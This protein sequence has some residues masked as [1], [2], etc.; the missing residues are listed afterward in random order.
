M[1][2]VREDI[3]TDKSY[4]HVD[5]TR[6]K[7]LKKQ[8]FI[9]F[10]I[11][12]VC[13][14]CSSMPATVFGQAVTIEMPDTVLA[15]AVRDA[16]GFGTTDPITDVAMLDLTRL[17]ATSSGPADDKI[18]DL[19]GLEHAANL[20]W[21]ELANNTISNVGPLAKLTNLTRL[22]LSSNNLIL[23]TSP[24][25][26]PLPIPDY[27]G[28]QIK[29]YPP[30]DVNTNGSV[31][32]E[33]VER[34]MDALRG[35]AVVPENRPMD[36][37]GSGYVDH[38]DL[39]LVIENALGLM[40]VDVPD[41]HLAAV[42]RSTLELPPDFPIIATL[43]RRLT[44]LVAPG[45]A[46]TDLTG[47]ETATNLTGLDLSDNLIK[48]NLVPLASLGNLD[49]LW[50][51]N[52]AIDDVSPLFNLRNLKRLDLGGNTISNISIL[53]R[54][55]SLTHLHLWKNAI[56]DIRVLSR[57]TNLQ[58]LNL[59][60]NTI[61]DIS[62]LS[63]LTTLKRLDLY[64]NTISDIR[65]LSGLTDLTW[66]SL[67]DNSVEDVSPLLSLPN[68]RSLFLED[69]PILDTS[70][71]YPK[72]PLDVDIEIS[73][74]PP[75]DVNEDGSVD[76]T[77]TAL[78][79][80]ALG[81]SGNSIADPRTD[82][83]GDGTVN[84]ADV[85]LVNDNWRTF[86]M[87]DANLTAAVRTVLG[88]RPTET[89]I[90]QLTKLVA[91]DSLISDLTGLEYATNLA[92]LELRD[93]S[94]RD[95]R[96]LAGLTNLR[97][98][99]FGDNS[100]GDI[101][102]VAGLT[103]LRSL[104]MGGNTFSDIRPIAGLTNLERLGV[105]SL[106]IRDINFLTRL[107]KL[108]H[109]GIGGNAIS[110]IRPLARLRNLTE[111]GL[112][113]N[114][115]TD[116]SP[117]RTL[118]NL[119]ELELNS[120]Q[121]TDVSPL[122]DLTA[123]KKLLLA[124]NPVLTQN[125]GSLV[126]LLTL[127][128]LGTEK[129]D[130]DFEF[131][132][133]V[134][135][136]DTNLAAAVREAL[137]LAE[138]SPIV[139]SQ[140]Q[141]L[142]SLIAL[143][144]GIIDL[145][146]LEGATGL[147]G[148]SLD[149]NSIRDISFLASLTDLLELALK[150][151]LIDDISSLQD[152]TNL[153]ELKL[154]NNRITDVSP[155]SGLTNLRELELQNNQITDVL[156]LSGLRNLRELKLQNN[157][158]MDVSPLSGLTNLKT[159][160][161]TGNTGITNVEV[162]FRLQLGGTQIKGVTV[163]NFVVFP[164]ANLETAVRTALSL[165]PNQPILLS[166]LAALTT[167]DA[168][169]STIA[170]LSGLE[171]ATAL[172]S[173]D[174][175][176]N[177]IT[178]VS[179]L[180]AATALTSLDLRDNQITDVS[181]L[182]GLTNLGTLDL[183]GNTGITNPAVLYSLQAGGT[184]I[185]IT[186]PD[187]VV[188]SDT[189]LADALRSALG[190]AADAPIPSA[191][192]VALTR[193]T[194]ANQGIADLM[195]LEN[196]VSLTTL[197]LRNNQITDV[198]PL[199][200][201]TNLRTLNLTGNDVSNPEALITL[202]QGG[203]R[204]TG[205]TVPDEVIFPDAA[206]ARKVRMALRLD[207]GVPI[208]S[209]R[210]AN[211][212]DLDAR[213]S[214]ITDLTGLEGATS[215]IKLSLRFNGIRDISALSRL[216]NL[217][218][219]DLQWNSISNISTL[220]KLTN[221]ESLNISGNLI[222]NISTLSSL[223]NLTDLSLDHNEISNISALSRL[224]NLTDLHLSNNTIS[225]ISVLSKL[226]S[227]KDLYLAYNQITNVSPL[228]GLMRLRQVYLTGN[229]VSNPG[230]LS[231]LKEQGTFIDIYIPSAVSI[232]DT[233]LAAAVREA[234]DLADDAAIPPDDLAALTTLD[235]SSLEITQL[236]GIEA[237][238][239]LTR[240]T[241]NDNQIGDVSPL[242]ALTRL[243]TLNLRDNQITDALPL[244]KLTSL[245]TLDVTNNPIENTGVLFI[246]KQNRTRIIGVTV[247]NV[248][249]FR[250]EALEAVVREV[251]D[252]TD[253][254]DPISPDGVATLTTLDASSRGISDLRGI[255]HAMQLETLHLRNNR[256][257]D[258]SPLV[259]LTRL[260]RLVLDGN[261]VENPEVLFRLEQA[262]TRITGVAVP[263]SV[264]FADA[265]LEATVRSAARVSSN[266]PL[267]AEK[268]RTLPGLTATRKEISDLTGIQEATGLERLDLGDNEITDI[269]LLSDLT[270]LENLDLADNE[271]TDVSALSN[272][273]SLETLDL[274]DN[275]V[276]DVSPLAG[277]TS[278]RQ[279][280]LRGNENLTTG[281]KQLV[282]LTDLQVDI[283]LPEPVAFPDTA[284]A[285][286]VRTE[287]NRQFPGLNLQPGDPIFPEDIA[288]LTQLRATN[289]SISDL[290]GLETATGLTRL[291][292]S[293]NDIVDVSPLSALTG[294]TE[295]DLQNNQITDVLPLASLTGLTQLNLSGNTG[296][297]NPEV[298]FRLKQ[299][300]TTITGVTVPDSVRFPDTALEEAVRNALRLSEHLPILPTN[301]QTLTTL[302][303]SRKGVTDLTGLQE[304]TQLTRLT[305]SDN[306][307][308]ILTPLS[309]LTNLT[310]LDLRNNQ[311]TDVLPLAGL[312]NLTRLSLDGNT[313][314]TNPGV[315]Y[316]LKQGGTTITGVT[317]P[318]AVAFPDTA[319]EE[320]VRTAL[321]LSS[322]EPIL[323]HDLAGLTTLSASSLG[324]VDLTGLEH[325]TG[326]MDLTLSNNQVIDVLPLVGLT[327]LTRLELTNNPITN[328]GV[329]FP[330]KQAGTTEI[331]GVPI[332]DAVGFPD[333]AL[334]TAVRSALRISAGETIL[335]DALAMLTRLTAARKEIT[336][337]S[338]LEHATG[339]ERLDLGQNENITDISELANLIH[340]ENLDLA[341]N[342][343]TDI[344]DL[345]DL[346][347][348][349]V[350]D[351]RNNNVTDTAL[352]STMTHLKNLYVLGNNGLS[353]LKELVRLTEAGT[354]VDIPLPSPVAFPDDNLKSA[355][356][357]ALDALST[358]T[359]QPNDPIF[360][361]DMEMLTDFDA[362]N[363]TSGEEIV[364]LT[365]LETATGLTTLNLSGNNIS[366]LTPL[367]KL[368]NL[369]ALTLTNNNISSLSSVSRL[370]GLTTLNL[371]GNRI[372]SVSSLSK[373]E[374]LETLALA[375]NQISSL[376]SLSDLTNLTDLDLSNNSIRDVLPLQ[377]LSSLTDLN[378]AG[379]MDL[380]QEKAE[381]LY[382]LRQGGTNITLPQGIELP[383]EAEIVVF[384]N[385]DL[386]TAVRSALR[387]SR[388]YPIL[389]TKITELKRLTVTRKE[390]ADLTGLEE[391]PGLE[392]L[393]LGDNAIQTLTPLR[394]LTELT[395]LDLADNDIV[396]LSSLQNLAAL[397]NL[398]LADNEIENV[399]ALSG[400]TNLKTLDLRNNDVIDVAPLRDLV[401]L[402]RIYL[403]GNE[404]LE[405]LEWLGALENLRADIQLPDV[406]RLPDTNL[407][408]A[409]RTALS[410]T[411]NL[412]MS[413]ELL[414]SLVA[415][416]ASSESIT[417]LTG[418]EYTTELTSLDLSNNQIT[419]VSPLSKLYNL[420][421]LML[422]ENPI[423][424]TS[425][426]RELERRGTTIDITIYRYPSWDVNQDGKVNE[427]DVF[428]IT[429]TITDE[430]PDVNG[431]GKVD[432]DD[433]TAADAN[434]DGTVNT[435]D[436]LLVFENFDRPVNLAAPLL[437]AES[438]E[439]DWR[440]L[441]R[442]D[443]DRLRVQLEILRTEND[444]SLKYRQAI[445]FLQAVLVA[446]HP[447]QTLL[448]ANYP[449][450]FNPE[451]WIPYQLAQGSR[452][453]ITIYDT[454]GAIVR[455]LELGY[456][457]EGYY[458]V[459]GRA[460][461]WDGRNTVGERVAS[462]LYFYQLETDDVSLLR[463]MVILK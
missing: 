409:V 356:R 383:N 394:N 36:V 235:A 137:G 7:A 116:V 451:T 102:I 286:A 291:T 207:D 154:Q 398:N 59:G 209:D 56:S 83:N 251:L 354:H 45:R 266:L 300:N 11:F 107:T 20:T 24:L 336:N 4:V 88:E 104:S 232:P 25:Y 89:S 182:V 280:Y 68:L 419:D 401:S 67:A 15:S 139:L 227:L 338:G 61:S 445:A 114:Q 147:I 296:I 420:Q 257:T 113:S 117:L 370:T 392:R 326:L 77:D 96:P 363:P 82:V 238:A 408:A 333:T 30:W 433:E 250:D 424:D 171:A 377:G 359:L 245:K 289:D 414:E 103:N 454:R 352:L 248:V 258:V 269:L 309:A 136:P 395:T 14:F 224:T 92:E 337:L 78:V 153:M 216:T 142:T 41:A 214:G 184:Q 101:S 421:T 290:T 76:A 413:E 282:P 16:L 272:L 47:L 211:L 168:S 259:G 19:T 42:V 438:V 318:D 267:T 65:D 134:N 87:P 179:P 70:V 460:A 145:T 34:V 165:Q 167:L 415:L 366:S 58:Q 108:T 9:Y 379:N 243:E 185:D 149:G 399:T 346:K 190:L 279:L 221:L 206:L 426:L 294:L 323:P 310:T 201:L 121:I 425:V 12:A 462:G 322:T 283:D 373:L 412:P 390:I 69:N 247:P 304:A 388:G 110:D 443:A 183:T 115:I 457:A 191:R 351:L 284:L 54:L 369:T 37:N 316:R 402:T 123:L 319:L 380:T 270:N 463:K 130:R 355:L 94:I 204:I 455:R 91:N 156:P 86:T 62:H 343:I 341:D 188:F 29:Q 241:L 120:N 436:L 308:A 386:E 393:D 255:E 160:D 342:G 324:I 99:E 31:N 303:V 135:M 307:I 271:I 21:L 46:I 382:K 53:S 292:L 368:T 239:G 72:L 95:L 378:L 132:S 374:A 347:K 100:V 429:A 328:P 152:L 5:F 33:D 97:S 13:V 240:L 254:D 330:L 453:R 51:K 26:R 315:L 208:L 273:I 118:T 2:K 285:A 340:L 81:Q 205:V 64:H 365:G 176:N 48:N 302:T 236:T 264:V 80:A 173:L 434:K 361:E 381:V 452:V 312:T 321:G 404:N 18:S 28:P 187:D 406:V 449:N 129:E 313:G 407:D 233:A 98:L 161:L 174:L 275:D 234:L 353:S 222:S 448:L 175:R 215:L 372:S 38:A 277:L 389:K 256:I 189:A 244:T 217:T 357:T 418:C 345:S 169:N 6:S 442:I 435:D 194:A 362:S 200:G 358:L 57:F 39:L 376:T 212:A 226:T 138:D 293:N 22:D 405:N 157:Q 396:D 384:K 163:P 220:S 348:L 210:L 360:P 159:L 146:G 397:T 253:T 364:N 237:A 193:L 441:E 278:L 371:D 422:D 35:F 66:L 410:V 55:G 43:M 246:L 423:L 461:H 387:I 344:S 128:N 311:I 274:R 320:A 85:T 148:L 8:K 260:T 437:S 93:N 335:P 430:S 79:T 75:W 192:L 297:T 458:R 50:L 325:A 230:V 196:A 44:H 17:E 127:P 181:P 391:A 178:D 155:L 339:L 263:D 317:I 400:L 403:R 63:G 218:E 288:Q 203:T 49:W 105:W 73:A 52:N 439:L 111:L 112:D 122:K 349:E 180:E 119:T 170:D 32:A 416:D 314:I 133:I 151:N 172:T 177:Q 281:L 367:A 298:L 417:D 440:L 213:S 162:L 164:D 447:N 144:R 427:A 444:G 301:M 197:D 124:N 375:D 262:G 3:K 350:L 141:T 140:L 431:D 229:L 228:A 276:M 428:L 265:N 287:L 225:D 10:L 231:I 109:L 202:D 106:S 219:L 252:L 126:A 327:N 242:S 143:D 23:D 329:L 199:A 150:G 125:P 60:Y 332:P 261:P 334:D 459:R 331:I 223:T 450:P 71:L 456:R 27:S 195:G 299:G 411:G 385:A 249:V 1:V 306:T 40:F 74:Y 158:I 295:L 186:L 305:L 131:P 268:M 432:A 90:L 446:L 166:S 84:N 198:S